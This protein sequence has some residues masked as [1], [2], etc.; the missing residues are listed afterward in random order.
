[1]KQCGF[2][3]LYGVRDAACPLSTRGATRLVRLVRKNGGGRGALERKGGAP[4][5]RRGGSR[6]RRRCTRSARRSAGGTANGDETCP[7]STEGWTRRVYFVREG[8]REE[9]VDVGARNELREHATRLLKH[10]AAQRRLGDVEA[11]GDSRE[12]PNVLDRGLARTARWSSAL[13]WDRD[14]VA[15]TQRGRSLVVYL[16]SP[17][18]I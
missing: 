17:S 13:G 6:G 14:L 2:T 8:G 5:S 4:C 9:D 18:M 1:M 3:R 12:V 11:L 10:V 16:D 7:V 15:V